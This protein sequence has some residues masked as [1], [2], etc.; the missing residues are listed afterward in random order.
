MT[1]MSIRFLITLRGEG[2]LAAPRLELSNGGSA[3]KAGQGLI[4]FGNAILGGTPSQR[5]QSLRVRNTGTA[6][7]TSLRA[8]FTGGG[9]Q[10]L[11]RGGAST[12]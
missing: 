9:R 11:Q 5:T 4:R 2:K 3:V 10:Q 7:L 12:H 1:R 6:P 8:R